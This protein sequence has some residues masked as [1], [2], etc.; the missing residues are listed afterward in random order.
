MKTKFTILIAAGLLIAGATQAQNTVAFNDGRD[1]HNVRHEMVRDHVNI[2]RD[3]HEIRNDRRNMR[4]DR[5]EIRHD[6]RVIHRIHRH[7]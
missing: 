3:R 6:R 7:K 2:I 5:H 4:F 1:F